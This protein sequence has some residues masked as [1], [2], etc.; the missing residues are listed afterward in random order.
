M[1]ATG[2]VQTG[3]CCIQIYYSYHLPFTKTVVEGWDR[4]SIFETSSLKTY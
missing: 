2:C 3:P 4:F 1:A